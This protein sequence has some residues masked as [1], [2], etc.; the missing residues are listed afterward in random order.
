MR[1]PTTLNEDA[2]GGVGVLLKDLLHGD[3]GRLLAEVA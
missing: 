2:R 3:L 1:V